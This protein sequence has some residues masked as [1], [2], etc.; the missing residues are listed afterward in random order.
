MGN[1]VFNFQAYA[2]FKQ[3]YCWYL[4]QYLLKIFKCIYEY[5]KYNL[6]EKL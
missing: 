3:F 1:L 5:A 4:L 2:I 6:V